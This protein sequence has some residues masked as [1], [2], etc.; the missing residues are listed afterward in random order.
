MKKLVLLLSMLASA[1]LFA[2]K[3]DLDRFHFN[4]AYQVLPK[5][6]VPL[7]KRTFG[8]HVK[9]SD[10]LSK[11]V[12]ESSMYE[13]I[14]IDGWKKVESDP[15]V[16]IDFVLEDFVY[17]GV[18]VK[19]ETI[20]DK[21]KD[22]NIKSSTTYYWLEARYS[23]RGYA[24]YKGPFTPIKE[25]PKVEEVKTV[26][27]FLANAVINKPTDNNSGD[28]QQI[29]LNKEIIHTT[30]KK[31]VR[32]V[33]VQEFNSSKDAIYEQTVR[34]FVKGSINTINYTINKNYGFPVINT[35]DV[36]WILDA[37]SEEGKTQAEAIEAVKELFNGMKADVPTDQ[38]AQ[39]LQPLI[40]YFESLKTKYAADDKPSR[41]IRYSAYFNLAKIYYYLDNPDKVIKE[42]EGLIK[43]DYDPKDGKNLIEDAVKLKDLFNQTKFS[44]RHN[45]SL[46]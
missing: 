25:V 6:N 27:R 18:E 40:D 8:L 16:G 46:K 17:K 19:S 11:Y 14:G 13:Q 37:K 30:N 20:N 36:L 31:T 42:A 1:P 33:A 41:K 29:N 43:N 24:K 2:Q 35:R 23:A 38:L 9:S 4:V 12:P 3:V 45:P 10:L 22:G 34:N 28:D 44:S 5:E 32:D 7:E 39:N 15:T 21:D 26:N